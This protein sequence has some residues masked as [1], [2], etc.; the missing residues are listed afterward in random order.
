VCGRVA[1]ET[2]RRRGRLLLSETSHMC[3]SVRFTRSCNVFAAVFRRKRGRR[4]GL[5]LTVVVWRLEIT[6]Q[7]S[8]A[9]VIARYSNSS[10]H[11]TFYSAQAPLQQ[12]SLLLTTKKITCPVVACSC[13]ECLAF[14]VPEREENRRSDAN[15]TKASG[16]WH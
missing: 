1:L 8:T 9:S 15:A 14:P 3:A 4:M 5:L 10:F 2:R 12:F 6:F 7:S 11:Q 13:R 16:E